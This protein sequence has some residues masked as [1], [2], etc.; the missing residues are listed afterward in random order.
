MLQ[1]L[2]KHCPICKITRLFGACKLKLTKSPKEEY[3]PT[4]TEVR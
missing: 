2:R 1:W 4:E 3:E